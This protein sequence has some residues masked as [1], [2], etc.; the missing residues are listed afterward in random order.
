[1]SAHILL[2]RIVDT[3]VE[4]CDTWSDVSQ[5]DFAQQSSLGVEISAKLKWTTFQLAMHRSTAAAA[6]GIAQ[7]MYDFVMQQKKRSERTIGLMIPPGTAASTAFAAYQE[8]QKRA[9]KSSIGKK[10]YIYC[11]VEY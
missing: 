9:E 5:D 2:L 7:R 3:C 1:M 6:F 8:D 11:K 10:Y 4:A